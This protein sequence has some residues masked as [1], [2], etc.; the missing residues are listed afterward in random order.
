MHVAFPSSLPRKI[1][2]KFPI[3]AYQGNA[4]D[5]GFYVSYWGIMF[6]LNYERFMDIISDAS[7]QLVVPHLFA[8]GFK[9]RA[10]EIVELLQ[11]GFN[12]NS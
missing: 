11:Q 9:T 5:C 4:F 6:K 12:M 3:V 10:L 8:N 2:Y 1:L 7:Q